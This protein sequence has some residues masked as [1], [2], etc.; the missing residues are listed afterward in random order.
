MLVSISL[1][2]LYQHI[3]GDRKKGAFGQI[4]WWSNLRIVHSVLY[5]ISAILFFVKNKHAYVPL[6]LDVI[7]GILSFINHHYL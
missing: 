6:L 7:I 5:A 3:K 2:F 1:G 4:V